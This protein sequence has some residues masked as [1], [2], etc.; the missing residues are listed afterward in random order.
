[1]NN[2]IDF[3]IGNIA[4]FKSKVLI[5]FMTFLSLIIAQ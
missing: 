1:M 5:Y 4:C 3:K 2:Y